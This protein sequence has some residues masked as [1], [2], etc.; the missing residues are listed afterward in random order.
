MS[1]HFPTR[2]T[3]SRPHVIAELCF[4]T[5]LQYISSKQDT[6]S[7]EYLTACLWRYKVFPPWNMMFDTILVTGPSSPVTLLFLRATPTRSEP[8]N[9][10]RA[11]SH[12]SGPGE[13][14]AMRTWFQRRAVPPLLHRIPPHLTSAGLWNTGKQ[15]LCGG[16]R[17]FIFILCYLFIFIYFFW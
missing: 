17:L 12:L 14:A 8:A 9:Q 1:T 16:G 4:R 11:V 3:E 10:R 2:W 13:S 15:Q 5:Q 6:P 7:L